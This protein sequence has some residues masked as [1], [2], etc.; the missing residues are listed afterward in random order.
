MAE[1]AWLRPGDAQRFVD[2]LGEL[3]PERWVE[4][5][6]QAR[7][8]AFAR[9]FA[10][11][12]LETLLTDHAIAVPLWNLRDDVETAA[13]YCLPAGYRSPDG[14]SWPRDL[15]DAI[16]AAHVAALAVLLRLRLGERRFA[17]LYAP[18]AKLVP[19]AWLLSS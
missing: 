19:R 13:W 12:A 3:P 4:A 16:H 6:L 15:V 7:Q 18:F 9:G 10:A 8:D 1:G 14:D 5:G 17:L 2:A 11:Q